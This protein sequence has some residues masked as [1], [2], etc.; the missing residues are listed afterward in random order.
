MATAAVALAVLVCYRD[1]LCVKLVAYTVWCLTK[2]ECCVLYIKHDKS[3]VFWYLT[4]Q[5]CCIL[6]GLTRVLYSIWYDKCCILSDMT[7]V[8][9]HV[10]WYDKSVVFYLIWPECLIPSDAW[11][12]KSDVFYLVPNIIRVLYS[13]WC[14]TCQECHILSNASDGKN[15]CWS[16]TRQLYFLRY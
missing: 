8:V 6:S 1:F 16:L 2:Y 15:E 7:N 13:I 9:L 3:A 14:L 11:H 12:D 10:I 4:L 5:E